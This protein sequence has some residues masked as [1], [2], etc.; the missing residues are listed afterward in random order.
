MVTSP[1]NADAADAST[2]SQPLRALQP[3]LSA[4]VPAYNEAEN[5]PA[6]LPRLIASLQQLT[7][8]WE[9][10]VVDDGSRDH[11]GAALAPF[12]TQAGVCWLRL[13]RNFGKEI[14]RA[15]V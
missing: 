12:L 4:V 5:L 6:L 13:S 9:V 14:G 11:T 10:V 15:H 7:E 8:H 2:G 3:T 1:V